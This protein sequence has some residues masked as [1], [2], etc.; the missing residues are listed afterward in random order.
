MSMQQIDIDEKIVIKELQHNSNEGIEK[1]ANR[2]RFSRQKV[3][4]IIKKL[5]KNNTIWGYHAII[6]SEKLNQKRYIV[7]VKKTNR[8]I[9]KLLETILSRE[10]EK[11]AADIG[12]SIQSSLYLHGSFDWF[13]LFTAENIK[14]AKKFCEQFNSIYQNY[15]NEIELIEEIFPVKRCGIQN[16]NIDKLR[17]FV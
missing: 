9:G 8:P 12:V 3:W 13:L 17:E 6:D 5:E 14:Q 2:C 11:N 10:I 4:R 1:I 7:L 16:P 15:V